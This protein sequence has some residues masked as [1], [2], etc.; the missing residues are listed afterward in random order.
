[1]RVLPHQPQ[2]HNAPRSAE[3]NR[4]LS[5][6]L[7]HTSSRPAPTVDN[8]AHVLRLCMQIR[9]HTHTTVRKQLFYTKEIGRVP[10]EKRTAF[11][12]PLSVALAAA[13]RTAAT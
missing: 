5:V 9:A 11:E 8:D 3:T 13:M 2:H 4:T 12:T 6:S 10:G 7:A 1:M